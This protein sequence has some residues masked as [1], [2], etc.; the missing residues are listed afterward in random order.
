MRTPESVALFL[1][2]WEIQGYRW[3]PVGGEKT[4][5][6]SIDLA[7]EGSR[8]VVERLTNAIDASL[9]L[10]CLKDSPLDPPNS[11]REGLRRWFGAPDGHISSLSEERRQEL[12]N[13]IRVSLAESGH[14]KKPTILFR[15][16]GLGQHPD[17]MPSTIL[18]LGSGNKLEKHYLCGAYGQGGSTTYAWCE[19][20]V[21]VSRREPALLSP[22]QQDEIGWTVVKYDNPPGAKNNVYLYLVKPDGSFPR[23]SLESVGEDFPPGTYIAHIAYELGKYSGRM[24][25]VGYRLLNFLLF[26]PI[27]PFWLDDERWRERRQIPGNLSRLRQ[28][29]HVEYSNLYEADSG[30]LAGLRVRYW[31]MKVKPRERGESF[32]YYLDSYLESERSPHTIVITL[33]GQ[34][35]GVMDKG[36]L[37]ANLG[38]SF[39]SNYLLVQ[40]E[41]DDLSLNM[42]RRLFVSTRERVREGEDRLE[43]LRREVMQVLTDDEQVQHLERARREQHLAASDAGAEARVRRI[44]DRYITAAQTTDAGQRGEEGTSPVHTYEPN[45]PPT[46]LEI[47]TPGDPLQLLPGEEK[48]LLIRC[49]G[50]NDLLTRRTQR[51][52][53]AASFSTGSGIRVSHTGLLH[54]GKLRV[55]ADIP[56]IIPVGTQDE[57][58]CTLELAN[59]TTLSDQRLCVVVAPPP[60]PPTHD[61][62]TTLSVVSS[63]DP[64]ELRQGRRGLVHLECDGPDELLSRPS[65]SA[66]LTARFTGSSGLT[67]LG[68]TDLR[69]RRI[70]VFVLA[71]GDVAVDTRDLFECVLELP[72]SVSLSAARA[73]VVVEAPEEEPGDRER[74]RVPNYVIRQVFPGD[75]N[76]NMFRWDETWVGKHDKSGDLLILWVSMGYG[77]FANDLA[78]RNLTPER[79]EGMQA[80]YAA[81]IGYHLWQHHQAHQTDGNPG[82]DEIEYQDELRRVAKTILLSMRPEAEID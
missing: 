63:T 22:G 5:A 36:F 37:K 56:D 18:G 40:V 65:N 20:S 66:T 10:H 55:R 17:D 3:V 43:L 30:D 51:A 15:D 35:Q 1:R 61:P 67:L 38:L 27:L 6:R 33:N 13:Q 14:P 59:G 60:P 79:M 26:D 4:N 9:E 50:A 39:L 44:L 80:K 32:S 41:C 23:M 58:R 47:A 69:S 8:P 73:C 68:H 11:P 31:V 49:D 48:T 57:L 72:G 34:V 82:T 45:E 29:G 19:Y 2:E 77:P 24:T 21:I 53:F 42:K 70:K 81:L 76:W 52:R 64:I 71:P 54:N 25:L 7:S 46:I 78:R 28:S 74:R 62:P 75:D 16:R 12:A